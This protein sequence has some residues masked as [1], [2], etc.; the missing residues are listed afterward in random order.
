MLDL[1][2]EELRA[3]V[4]HSFR[5]VLG[6]IRGHGIGAPVRVDAEFRIEQ[7]LGHRVIVERTPVGGVASRFW[8]G[9]MERRS[10]ARGDQAR[11]EGAPQ[12][13]GGGPAGSDYSRGKERMG[14]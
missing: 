7:P 6:L 4:V 9:G 8:F 12:K 2:F 14:Q 11:S 5:I 3:G 1:V 10:P 13:A